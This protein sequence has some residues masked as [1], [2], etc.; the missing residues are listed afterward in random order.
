MSQRPLLPLLSRYLSPPPRL[1]CELFLQR[2]RRDVSRIAVRGHIICIAHYC[3]HQRCS[4]N[5]PQPTLFYA[6]AGGGGT[7]DID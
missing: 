3:G 1:G 6:I 5:P 7:V 4:M 2:E